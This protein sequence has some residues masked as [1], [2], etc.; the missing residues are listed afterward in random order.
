MQASGSTTISHGLLA[1][2]GYDSSW[3]Q[4]RTHQ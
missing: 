1:Y 2:N 4:N 3:K